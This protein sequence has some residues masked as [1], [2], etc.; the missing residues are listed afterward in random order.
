MRIENVFITIEGRS[1]ITVFTLQAATC[2]HDLTALTSNSQVCE[3]K[4]F[5]AACS[6][7]T[8]QASLI[9]APQNIWYSG[10]CLK[11]AFKVSLLLVYLLLL[12]SEAA[13]S[14]T[15]ACCPSSCAFA[16]LMTSA[17]YMSVSKC[18]FV[19]CVVAREKHKQKVTTWWW[20]LATPLQFW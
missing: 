14:R 20:F 5:L 13:A 19:S 3:L 6:V 15:L 16:S 12:Q 9:P 18:L 7:N 1:P 10:F 17:C 4:C 8:R 11:Y 2:H